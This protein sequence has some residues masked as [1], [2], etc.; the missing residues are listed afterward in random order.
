MVNTACPQTRHLPA[1]HGVDALVQCDGRSRKGTAKFHAG[2]DFR[3]PQA[4]GHAR[5]DSTRVATIPLCVRTTQ[6]CSFPAGPE[7]LLRHALQPAQG[8]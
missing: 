7:G 3:P 8:L 2:W 4:S 5:R 6:P 1:S